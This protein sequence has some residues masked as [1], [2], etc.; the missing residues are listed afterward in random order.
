MS[1]I[2]SLKE[3]DQFLDSNNR[4]FKGKKFQQKLILPGLRIKLLP[5]LKQDFKVKGRVYKDNHVVI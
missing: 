4:I 2:M 1:S 5:R 3:R